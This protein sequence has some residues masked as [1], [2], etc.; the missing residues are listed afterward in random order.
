[1]PKRLEEAA[2]DRSRV[3]DSALA[4]LARDLAIEVIEV[5]VLDAA[6]SQLDHLDRVSAGQYQLTQVEAD[7]RL[8]AH[9]Q[10]LDVGRALDHAATARQHRQAKPVHR[11]HV[12][13][14]S[15]RA[16]Q[17]RPAR[18]R[19]RD[20]IRAV[21]TGLDDCQHQ[22]VRTKLREPA[23]VSIDV[24]QLGAANVMVMQDGT[25]R[26]G[27]HAQ[28]MSPQ[29]AA[30][31]VAAVGKKTG[32][33]CFDGALPEGRDLVQHALRFELLAPAADLADAPRRGRER[34]VVVMTRRTR[35]QP[36]DIERAPRQSHGRQINPRIYPLLLC[37]K[38]GYFSFRACNCAQKRKSEL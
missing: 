30:G 4:H 17:V 20:A 5:D 21:L 9:Q 23:G 36:R 37:T 6:V 16:Q 29:Q 33:S 2:R 15:D 28:A 8:R 13:H 19:Q 11:A 14:G 1:M 10:A 27:H 34:D 35:T 7:A 31:G 38:S 12:L 22:R 32:R 26:T 18:A 25:H 24:R 3:V